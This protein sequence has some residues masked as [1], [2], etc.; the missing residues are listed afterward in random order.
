MKKLLSVIIFASIAVT[1]GAQV[2]Y[3][4]A[5]EFPLYGKASD[6]MENRYAR[7]PDSLEHISR[8]PLWTLG[9][10]SAGLAVRFSSDSPVI[11]AR[12]TNLY[13]NRM[14]HMTDTGVKGLDLYV[15]DGDEW[16]FVNSARPSFGHESEAV[17]I[18]NMEPLE[19][20]YMLYLPLYDGLVSLEIGIDSL[21]H[22]S[23]P[24]INSPGRERPVV[25]YGTSLLQGACA[26]RAG[27]AFTNIISRRLDREAINLGFSGNAFLDYEIAHLMAT[28]DAGCYVLDFVPNTSVELIRTN[29]LE[30]YRILRDA[31]PG[32]PIIFI[33]DP[34]FPHSRYDKA[35]AHEINSKNAAIKEFYEGLIA[36]GQRDIYYIPSDNMIGH[37]AEATI[38]A[39]HFTDVGMLRYVDLVCPVI[40]SVLEYR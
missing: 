33:E 1:S 11:A 35:I 12:W 20:E 16:R 3:Y 34:I 40:E 36:D 14:N 5:A 2:K 31:R 17:I 15:M 25:F 28:V 7:L 38:D 6:A 37:D 9:R 23:P 8:P 19:R 4:D 30:F 32:I 13:N 27:M 24:N 29:A 18:S 21:S 10:N 22:I 26:S 39:I